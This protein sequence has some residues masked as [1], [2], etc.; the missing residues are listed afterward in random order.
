MGQWER[1]EGSSN[2]ILR[3]DGFYISY[4][5]CPGGGSAFFGSDTD[6]P[7]TAIVKEISKSK[8]Q[9]FILNGDYREVYEKLFLSGFEPCK[10]FYDQ[11]KVHAGS[12]WSTKEESEK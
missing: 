1:V 7:E 12:S 5:P 10:R 2:T 8:S 4:N 9:F 6:G 3:G 11:E